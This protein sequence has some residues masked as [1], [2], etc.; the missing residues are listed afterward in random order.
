MKL[1]KKFLAL[2][3]TVLMILPSC[4]IIVSAASATVSS[5]ST[6]TV[7]SAAT[8]T[9]YSVYGS[10]SGHTEYVHT[11]T[12]SP[13]DGYV[14]IPYAAYGGNAA[15]TVAQHVAAAQ[16]D[17]YDVIAAVNG[18]FFDMDSGTG[19]GTL[20]SNGIIQYS[21]LYSGWANPGK[22]GATTAEGYADDY[23]KLITFNEDGSIELLR[24]CHNFELTIDG[25]KLDTGVF[26]TMGINRH[27]N[28]DTNSNDVWSRASIYYYDASCGSYTDTGTAT[29]GI[30][31]ICEKIDNTDAMF[32]STIRGKV[33]SVRTSSNEAPIGDNQ[34]VLFSL[35]NGSYA[36]YLTAL[37]AGDI[38]E[39][40][41]TQGVPENADKL[42]SAIGAMY[43]CG[44][45][46]ANGVDLTANYS[47]IGDGHYVNSTYAMWSCLGVKSD[48]SIMLLTSE[49]GSTGDSSSSLHLS[50]IAAAMKKMGCVDVYRFD[51][52]GSTGMWVKGKGMVQSQS[53]Q[54]SDVVLIVKK[55]SLTNTAL[56][57]E[58]QNQVNKANSLL[59]SITD[60]D[61]LAK[62]NEAKALLAKS[63][64][65]ATS[66]RRVLVDLTQLVN[67]NSSLEGLVN[68]IESLDITLYTD[69]VL[70]QIRTKYATAKAHVNAGTTDTALYSELVALLGTADEDSPNKGSVYTT[71]FNTS[72]LSDYVSIFT[73]SFGT[74]TSANANHV[75]TIN[76]L[77]EKV[78]GQDY[79]TVKSVN[80]PAGSASNVTLSSN[81]LLVA[82]HGNDKNRT[83]ATAV[84]A[85]T[86]ATLHGINVSSKTMDV[87]SYISFGEPASST[88]EV[89]DFNV[90]ATVTTPVA[91]VASAVPTA[92]KT[93][94]NNIEGIEYV[95]AGW[96]K[97]TAASGHI[98][99]GTKFESN[100]D[101]YFYITIKA[102]DGYEFKE[103]VVGY[104]FNGKAREAKLNGSDGSIT[105]Y[106]YYTTTGNITVAN[107]NATPSVTAPVAGVAS[108][109]P[110]AVKTAINGITGIEYVGAGWSTST[111]SAGHITAGTKFAS[112]TTYYF[113]TKIKADA[114]YAFNSTISGY[115]FN[116][117]APVA[118]VDDSG[119]IVLY[120][121][122]G[123]TG[124]ISV[125]DFNAQAT[126]T[127]PVADAV[128]TSN[129]TAVK[130]AIDGITGIEYVAAGWSTSTASTGH[131]AAGTKFAA[132]TKYFYYIT[133]KPADGYS[134]KST[135]TGYKL[136]GKTRTNAAT[137]DGGAITLY[138]D[139]GTTGTITVSQFNATAGIVAPVTGNSA[140]VNVNVVSAITG[141]QVTGAGWSTSTAS[142]GHISGGKF[143]PDTQYY[144][145]ITVKAN[146]GYVLADS[147]SE[148]LVNGKAPV[149]NTVANGAV[150]LYYDY[151][152]TASSV[153]TGF[154]LNYD[155][156]DFAGPVAGESADRDVTVLADMIAA[157]ADFTLDTIY[158]YWTTGSTTIKFNDNAVFDG[159]TTYYLA[160]NFI[161]ADGTQFDYTDISNFKLNGVAPAWV[162]DSYVTLDGSLTFVY[163]MGTTEGKSSDLGDMN[164]DGVI[165]AIDYALLKRAVLGSYEIEDTFF[166]IAD[167]NGDGVL[168]A[169]DYALLK[170]AVLGTY[171][172]LG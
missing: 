119:A 1:T 149:A 56:N 25:V 8:Y 50:D 16:A 112:S 126:I 79:Y 21:P 32:G 39:M 94:I 85:G 20:M 33:V 171:D 172:L 62:N 53:R 134:F 26:Q 54:V 145:Y 35:S 130:N 9:K 165:D 132:N 13:D 122:Y 153:I 19:Y 67:N 121:D 151:G 161:P 114:G 42:N 131:V 139:Y 44:S 10:S 144:F 157:D 12:A 123:K 142:A 107:Y 66:V 128:I 158:S 93:A 164:S 101:Y 97:D 29:A 143:A 43:H 141:A 163:L 148:Y 24:S 58:L 137:A 95:A 60:A 71:H 49:G 108:A 136:N 28:P 103:N 73:S 169:I 116:G 162:D 46:V 51:G 170:R 77:L 104:K 18:M 22:P 5:V 14:A 96:S 78:S 3:L 88:K 166:N 140:T 152:K 154:D 80:N 127:A 89:A 120:Y 6:S 150:T 99:A 23:D 86:K 106:Y 147:Y 135:N 90:S 159:G 168:D 111:S 15:T 117:K 61:L 2:A 84:V 113:Y 37:S 47:E 160:L 52:G 7:D 27:H 129:A 17:G 74:I 82:V 38:V 133:I 59:T 11:V 64:P 40:D 70:D 31:V 83:N 156:N 75:W 68:K 48:G 57:T 124:T 155:V 34:F 30:E 138:Y 167:I 100:T 91:G 45:L 118:K 92:V 102:D 76:L 55:S 115:K 87:L 125:A 72:I 65:S 110:T 36:S 146:T 105:L 98:T 69:D 4:M 81:Q 109:V 63:S 41:V